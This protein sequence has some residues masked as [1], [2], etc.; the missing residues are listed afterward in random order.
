MQGRARSAKV[1]LAS[2]L[3]L[4]SLD[5]CEF[6]CGSLPRHHAW[7]RQTLD[8]RPHP[9]PPGPTCLDS[10]QSR[11]EHGHGTAQD[12]PANLTSRDSA[13]H[14]CDYPRHSKG[15]KSNGRPPGQPLLLEGFRRVLT[16]KGNATGWYERLLRLASQSL[17]MV[18][19]CNI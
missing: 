18:F 3:P 14:C 6:V 16:L 13:V 1:N 9:T 8:P 19:L 12:M 10:T 7:L 17:Q 15:Q 11:A 2:R 4:C 5:P